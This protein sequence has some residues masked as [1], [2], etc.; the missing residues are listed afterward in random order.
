MSLGESLGG[1]SL[2]LGLGPWVG[3]WVG[4]GGWLGGRVGC[5]G[6]WVAW[7]GGLPREW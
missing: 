1:V 5:L 3:E 2:V 4:V 7:V 6:G